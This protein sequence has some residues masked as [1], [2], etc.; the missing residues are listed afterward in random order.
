ML[1]KK[2]VSIIEI[3]VSLGLISIVLIFLLNLF[4]Q[5]RGNYIQSKTEADFGTISAGFIKAIGDDIEN[6]GLKSV[7]YKEGVAN[8]ASVILTFDAYRPTMLSEHIKKVLKVYE[9]D[10][11]F[12]IS[13]TYDTSVMENK[14]TTSAERLTNLVRSLPSDAVLNIDEFI[15]IEHT[16]NSSKIKAV[17]I[18]LYLMNKEGNIYDINVSGLLSE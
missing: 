17:T 12:Y 5:F 15:T 1:N 7:E 16:S 11:Q 9:L 18:N 8:S 6:Y 14:S 3:I 13:Y 2:G 10:G 4:I